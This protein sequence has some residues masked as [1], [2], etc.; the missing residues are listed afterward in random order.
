MD[1]IG[2]WFIFATATLV[3]WGLW[4]FFPKLTT[5]YIS[6][7]SAL[8]WEVV[9]S[10]IV[11]VVVLAILGFKLETHP[12]GAVYGILTGIFGLLGALAF[13]YAISKGKASVT[14][15]M[16]ALYPLVTILLSYFILQET[17][18]LKQGAGMVFAFIAM[19]LFAI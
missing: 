5:T 18:T 8:V 2:T 6:P 9:G 17:I 19:I 11:G 1:K 7:R 12:K 3:L 4:G 15:T 14:V 10:M 16:T 13:L